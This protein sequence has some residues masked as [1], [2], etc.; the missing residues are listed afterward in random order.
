LRTKR[1]EITIETEELLVVKQGG[2]GWGRMWCSECGA[3]VQAWKP[4]AAAAVIGSRPRQIYRWVE[5]GS[6]HFTEDGA[7]SLLIC[8]NSLLQLRRT[9]S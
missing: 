3:T 9:N 8:H 2:D 6:V 5:S 7:G 1:T 4:P